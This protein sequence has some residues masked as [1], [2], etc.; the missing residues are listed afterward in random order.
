[1]LTANASSVLEEILHVAKQGIREP[2]IAQKITTWVA[3]FCVPFF[4]SSIPDSVRLPVV[5][6]ILQPSLTCL[7]SVLLC[8]TLFVTQQEK[9]RY[10]TNQ[11]NVILAV[12][13]EWVTVVHVF[14]IPGGIWVSVY[15]IMKCI[16]SKTL[17]VVCCLLICFS[18][19]RTLQVANTV[20]IGNGDVKK[21]LIFVG[22][23]N[24]LYIIVTINFCRA[25]NKA[26][27]TGWDADREDDLYDGDAFMMSD[28]MRSQHEKMPNYTIQ[29]VLDHVSTEIKYSQE[30]L[31]TVNH[32]N[33]APV[34]SYSIPRHISF[35]PSA[36]GAS[37]SI[38]EHSD[39]GMGDDEYH[40]NSLLPAKPAPSASAEKSHDDATTMDVESTL[41]LPP[42]HPN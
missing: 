13:S 35:T 2:N 9:E 38:S 29:D 14:C 11:D 33:A 26:I 12:L 34:K 3:C 4:L 39:E 41:L 30:M 36:M 42:P 40:T 6:E 15:L 28:D 31:N 17:S 7:A 10:H 19:V 8:I 37:A 32:H 25:E 21:A 1:M 20:D 22:C 18:F 23:L 24:F 27:Q 5:L 16:R